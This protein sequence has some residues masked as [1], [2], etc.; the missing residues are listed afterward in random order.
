MGSLRKTSIVYAALTLL[1]LAIAFIYPVFGHGVY[2]VYL[3]A[4]CPVLAVFGVV[5][6][7]CLRP[8]VANA[9]GYRLFLNAY[10]FGVATIVCGLLLSGVFDIAGGD[11]GIVIWFFYAGPLSSAIGLVALVYIFRKRRKPR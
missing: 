6:F 7:L 5:F 3:F 8:W 2:S 11:S 4:V 1:S 9:K 10:N